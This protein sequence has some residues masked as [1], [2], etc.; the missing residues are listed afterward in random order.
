MTT[1]MDRTASAGHSAKSPLIEKLNVFTAFGLGI[2][3]A[4]VFYVLAAKLIPED[5]DA[6]LIHTKHDQIILL[7]MIG[8]FIGFMVGIGALIG[9][10]RWL[11]GKDLSHDENMF[12]AGKI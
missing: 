3:L 12:Y 8:W 5:T 10:F 9:P 4:V 7:A 11:L 2:I 6:M 1:T